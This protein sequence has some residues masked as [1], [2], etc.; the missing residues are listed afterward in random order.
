LKKYQKMLDATM[1]FIGALSAV[2][3]DT[4]GYEDSI[5]KEMLWTNFMAMFT[6]YVE[7]R[8]YAKNLGYLSS[9]LRIIRLPNGHGVYTLREK[10]VS[11]NL[12]IPKSK[13]VA[14]DLVYDLINGLQTLYPAF[15]FYIPLAKAQVPKIPFHKCSRMRRV[16]E[17]RDDIKDA[18][19]SE[20]VVKCNNFSIDLE[21]ILDDPRTQVQRYVPLATCKRSDSMKT[22]Y[23]HRFACGTI[24]VFENPYLPLHES[25]ELPR[26]AQDML[27]VATSSTPYVCRFI[28]ALDPLCIEQACDVVIDKT[29]P[30]P[31]RLF[32][33]DVACHCFG[34][35]DDFILVVGG[36]IGVDVMATT[37]EPT[38]LVAEIVEMYK[39]ML[40][41]QRT[42]DELLATSLSRALAHFTKQEKWKAWL[43]RSTFIY[44][45][46]RR[47]KCSSVKRCCERYPALTQS[48]VMLLN[49]LTGKWSREMIE[50]AHMLREHCDLTSLESGE[51]VVQELTRI[52]S[53]AEVVHLELMDASTKKHSL[54]DKILAQTTTV[55]RGAVVKEKDDVGLETPAPATRVE[56]CTYQ[57][58]VRRLSEVLGFPCELIGSGLF[59]QASDADVVVTFPQTF[60]M[61]S[62]HEYIVG[63]VGFVPRYQNMD[64]IHVA[65]LRGTFEEVPVD[66]QVWRGVAE[67][68]AE[69]CTER[70]MVLSRRLFRETDSHCK[71]CVIELHRFMDIVKLKGHVLCMLSGIAITCIAVACHAAGAGELKVLLRT[72]YERILKSDTPSLSLGSTN[73]GD[74]FESRTSHDDQQCVC[75]LTVL[76]ENANLTSRVTVGTTQHLK[77]LLNAHRCP[78]RTTRGAVDMWRKHT[79][80]ECVRVWPRDDKA[81]C[82]TLHVAIARMDG[83][84]LINAVHVDECDGGVLVVR[85]TL[86]ADADVE[87]YGFTDVDTVHASSNPHL[88]IVRRGNREWP[89]ARQIHRTVQR[90]HTGPSV[91]DIIDFGNGCVV[92]NAPTLTVDVK[93]YFDER[94]WHHQSI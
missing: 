92:P 17:T 69:A 82:K 15:A 55:P 75:P 44:A 60:S 78:Q 29:V 5:G 68:A 73:L 93:S 90:S 88:V 71:R 72:L 9:D 66:L 28:R 26:H 51:R 36:T 50:K 2:I 23:W 42:P 74:A 31:Q 25:I 85:A 45:C 38:V 14:V 79:M 34:I 4:Q 89:L 76:S 94:F 91:T 83:H 77:D 62:A 43:P 18:T 54:G 57:D 27:S 52:E 58:L 63:K 84:P 24:G 21:K 22:L 81:A 11:L 40:C 59:Y 8:S 7:Y 32:V 20:G 86:A 48:L 87:R 37:H 35:T 53:D 49:G 30:I 47:M 33:A 19:L 65:V 67:S 1:R 39:H 16:F 70:A 46:L 12:I 41:A 80:I 56:E 3:T 10:Q 64:Q 13:S 6:D 61:E